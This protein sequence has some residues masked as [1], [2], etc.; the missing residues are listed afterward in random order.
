MGIK[1]RWI[2]GLQAYWLL[3]LDC[4]KLLWPGDNRVNNRYS[5]PWSLRSEAL[6]KGSK[7]SLVAGDFYLTQEPPE[8][9]Q[10][11][12]LRTRSISGSAD[13]SRIPRRQTASSAMSASAGPDSEGAAPASG[14]AS[15][16]GC[17]APVGGSSFLQP[18][19]ARRVDVGPAFWGSL[20]RPRALPRE[21]S[22]REE[23][24]GIGWVPLIER[25]HFA[26]SHLSCEVDTCPNL[27]KDERTSQASV[28]LEGDI[29]K[30]TVFLCSSCRGRLFSGEALSLHEPFVDTAASEDAC[31]R[32]AL[33][34]VAHWRSC[35]S[36]RQILEDCGEPYTPKPRRED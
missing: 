16:S 6:A 8:S 19:Q 1:W 9:V 24:I 29:A 32:E 31:N 33:A 2:S 4:H 20:M 35:R 14:S 12:L 11:I 28:R 26:D 7:R 22:R 34:G 3:C 23:I 10:E 13:R 17:N 25:G 21:R 36:R 5:A 30:H 18:R 15:A 27:L